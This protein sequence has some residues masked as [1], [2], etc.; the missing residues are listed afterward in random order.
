MALPDSA[1]VAGT[2]WRALMQLACMLPQHY[3][4]RPFHCEYD[5]ISDDI[6]VTC[7]TAT[8]Q[9]LRLQESPDN[10][11]SD[12]LVAQLILVL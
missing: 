4:D 3:H 11:P 8:G 6:I 7:I 12:K 10:F 2:N 1:K 9:R 5:L